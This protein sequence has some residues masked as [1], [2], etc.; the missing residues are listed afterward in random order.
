MHGGN[1]PGGQ[2]DGWE[3]DGEDLMGLVDFGP[4]PP[5]HQELP[6]RF[7]LERNGN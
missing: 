7:K 4:S 6:D 5:A 3:A 2:Q 1:V